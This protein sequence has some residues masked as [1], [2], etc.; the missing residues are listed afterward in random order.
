[1][2]RL[3]ILVLV[4][5]LVAGAAAF[6]LVSTGGKEAPAAEAKAPV[7]ATPMV[8][9]LMAKAD[10]AQGAVITPEA[11]KW[12]R[13]PKSEVPPFY[14]TEENTEFFEALPQMRARNLIRE[15]EPVFAQNTV[16]HGDRGMMAAIMTPGMRAVTARVTAEQSAGGFVLP[17]DRVDIFATGIDPSDP[18]GKPRTWVIY[19]NVRV[20]AIDQ[21][22]VKDEESNAII[23]KT[24]TLEV[25]PDQ[26][27]GFLEARDNQSL[28]LVLRSVFDANISTTVER[29]APD[30]VIV[31]RYGQG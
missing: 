31:I 10:I 21:I 24:V 28:T 2:N 16:R 30:Q 4:I 11:T 25:A 29:T 15:H 6:F 26:V 23:G 19:S 20:L 18:T 14:V 3:R 5:A 27:E 22:H 17:G 7:E 9:V 12:V 13:W 8:R 1:M